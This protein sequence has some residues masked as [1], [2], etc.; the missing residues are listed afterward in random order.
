MMRLAQAVL[1]FGVAACTACAPA[2]IQPERPAGADSLAQAGRG[3]LQ[4]ATDGDGR[5]IAAV[6]PDGAP[7]HAVVFSDGTLGIEGGCN[8]M[9]ADYRIDAQGRLVVSAIRSTLMACADSALMDADTAVAG[10][11]QGVSEW[12]IAESYPEQLF[13]EH[14]DGRRSQWVAD[15]P[16]D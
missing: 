13:L 7:A 12:R 3:H 4:G 9:G 10:L 5:R 14:G 16:S 15:R 2:V 1:A 6:A 8:R 11:L